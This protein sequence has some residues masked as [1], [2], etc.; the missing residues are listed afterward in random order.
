MSPCK[1]KN[2]IWGNIEHNNYFKGFPKSSTWSSMNAGPQT[3]LNGWS[4]NMVAVI[5]LNCMMEIT[6]AFC[7]APWTSNNQPHCF[8]FDSLPI[9]HLHIHW[10]INYLFL[11]TMAA[12]RCASIQ[13]D[14]PVYAL[15]WIIHRISGIN[16]YIITPGYCKKYRHIYMNKKYR[17]KLRKMQ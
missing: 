2:P 1:N 15:Y 13:Y 11:S 10:D 16:Q 4:P 5:F 8:L 6:R 3:T 14:I 9:S 17:K 7:F 12:L